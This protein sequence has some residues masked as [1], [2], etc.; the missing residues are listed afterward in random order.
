MKS[1]KINDVINRLHLSE[2][3]Q[4]DDIPRLPFIPEAVIGRRPYDK[5]D[6]KRRKLER[7][8]EEESG[9]PGVYNADHQSKFYGITTLVYEITI[10]VSYPTIWLLLD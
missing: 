5:T 3:Q 1:Q 2:P 10:N 6:P 4:R 9:G 8:I 7:D